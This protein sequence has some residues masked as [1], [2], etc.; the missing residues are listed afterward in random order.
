MATAYDDGALL[1]AHLADL[2][3]KRASGDH[4]RCWFPACGTGD[5]AYG[6]AM[7][8]ADIVGRDFCERYI[9]IFATDT[10]ADDAGRSARRTISE[11]RLSKLSPKLPN[12]LSKT[13]NM[14][15]SSRSIRGMMVFA[16]HDLLCDPPISR[17]DLIRCNLVSS[18]LDESREKASRRLV[19]L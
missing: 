18:S 3:E 1:Q 6:T 11:K 5:D 14:R 15:R 16:Q 17:L 9:K 10:S 19:P 2:I 8:L 7:W 13:A 4:L 12:I